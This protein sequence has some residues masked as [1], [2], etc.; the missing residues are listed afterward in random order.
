MKYL[1]IDLD[2]S[3]TLALKP[4]FE[5]QEAHFSGKQFTLHCSIIERKEEKKYVYHLSHD[6]ISVHE[7][8]EDVSQ[9][10]K[11]KKE[12]IIVKSEN[13]PTQY[14]NKYAFYSLQSLANTYNVQIIRIYGA[15]GHGKGLVNAMS[16]FGVKSA[17]RRDIITNG[18]LF[19]SSS[20]I[21]DY[22][23]F[24]GAKRMCYINVDSRRMNKNEMPIK[25]TTR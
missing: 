5:V 24:L 16:G 20:E 1:S 11:I 13:A 17:L 10:W 21:R 19:Q 2:F 7:A 25:M 8:L 4:N 6:P 9:N 22:L 3:S 12:T 23:Q 18:Q 14:K 15:A